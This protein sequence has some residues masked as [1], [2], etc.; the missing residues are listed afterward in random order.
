MMASQVEEPAT[1]VRA[2]LS[3]GGSGELPPTEEI[4]KQVMDR[5]IL[6]SIQLQMGERAGIQID[7][8][9]LNQTMQQ[10]AERN[11]VTLEQFR[12]ALERDGISYR[13]EIG[14]ATWR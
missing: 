8:P 3:R 11:G 12:A 6:E 9:S 10:L 14:R 7:D 1:S 4:R 5:L 2:Q 13:Q